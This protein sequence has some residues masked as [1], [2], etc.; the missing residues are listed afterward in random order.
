MSSEQV[1]QPGRDAVGIVERAQDWD[2]RGNSAHMAHVRRAYAVASIA[3]GLRQALCDQGA[4]P[5]WDDLQGLWLSA[6]HAVERAVESMDEQAA[7]AS[8]NLAATDLLAL[9]SHIDAMR[10]PTG[11]PA[12]VQRPLFD[13]DRGGAR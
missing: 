9:A 3:Q 8:L 1:R 7:S 12:Y 6:A 2:V 11:F 13:L 10:K 4:S 5:T